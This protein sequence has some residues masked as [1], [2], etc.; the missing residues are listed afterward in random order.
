MLTET[1]FKEIYSSYE[2][3]GLSIRSFCRNEG[4]N[5]A[6]FYYW[7]RR[8]KHF[9]SPS[10]GFIPI[11]IESGRTGLSAMSQGKFPT[12]FNSVFNSLPESPISS[13]CFEIV[14]PNGTRLKLQGIADYELIKSLILLTR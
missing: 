4:I 9:L 10:S 11:Q 13:S 8:L 12:G 1:Q 14:Y 3:S 6:K 5:E 7:K 2:S